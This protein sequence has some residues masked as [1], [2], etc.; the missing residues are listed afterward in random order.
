MTKNEKGPQRW[1]RPPFR[2]GLTGLLSFGRLGLRRGGL[3]LAS[4]A[5][6]VAAL[7]DTRRLTGAATQVIELGATNGAAA[8]D[9]DRVDGRRIERED[10]LDTFAEADLANGE[11]GADALVRA[12]DADA[13]EILDTGALAFDHLDADAQRVAGAEFGDGAGR[14]QFVDLFA[15]EGLNQVHVVLKP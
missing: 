14:R 8:D 4:L 7:S 12:G 9:L 1:L 2:F 15:L 11:V 10:A 6:R 3:L 13:L 5:A